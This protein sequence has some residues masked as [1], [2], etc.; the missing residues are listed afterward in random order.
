[1]A[2][3]VHTLVIQLG[4]LL[5]CVAC[6]VNPGLQILTTGMRTCYEGKRP[7]LRIIL[8]RIY[9]WGPVNTIMDLLGP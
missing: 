4:E 8:Q 3:L 1:M 9:W 7:L 5:S 6:L 2:S